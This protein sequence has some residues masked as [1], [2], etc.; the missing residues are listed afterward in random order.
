MTRK[1]RATGRT[2]IKDVAAAAGVSAITVSRVLR[3]PERVSP[4]TRDRVTE[5]VRALDYLPD[6]AASALASQRT[7]T[8]GVVLPSVTNTVFRDTL[9]GIYA[10]AAARAVQIQIANTRYDPGEEARAIRLFLSQ[11]PAALIVTGIDQSEEAATLLAEAPCPIVQITETG[12][13]AH[14]MMIGFDHG[15]AVE[16]ATRHLIAAGYRRIG[17][18]G[19][20]QDPRSLRR[21]EGF[22]AALRAAGLFEPERVLFSDV[23]ASVTSGAAQLGRLLDRDSAAAAVLC[24]NDDLALG[25]LFECQRRGL[26]V[27]DRIGICGFNDFE[28]M[29]AAVPPLTSVSTPRAEIGRRAMA[30]I[31]ERLENPGM[32]P[33]VVQL[34]VSLKIRESTRKR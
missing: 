14:D 27:P 18:L 7:A 19:A 12:P 16:L 11:R 8:V 10:E 30:M 9:R 13:S 31:G 2:T 26:A 5:A 6:P 28:W 33:E 3:T 4:A 24:N 22:C 1:T 21:M 15:E 23:P 34:D 25:V 29:A 17:F 20:R 32:A